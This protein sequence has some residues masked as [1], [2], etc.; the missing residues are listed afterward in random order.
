MISTLP[1]SI[2]HITADEDIHR[3]LRQIAEE[4]DHDL[5]SHS[6]Q[7]AVKADIVAQVRYSMIS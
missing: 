7:E 4:Q 5:C 6:T 1:Q 3:R 2:S